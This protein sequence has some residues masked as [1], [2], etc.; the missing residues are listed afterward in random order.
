LFSHPLLSL[1]VARGSGD[2]VSQLGAVARQAGT[3]VSLH[4]TGGAWLVGGVGADAGRF[5]AAVPHSL[6]R[7]VCNTVNLCRIVN[8]RALDLVP[9]FLAALDAAGDRRG[10]PSRLHVVEGSEG[11][12]PPRWFARQVEVRRAEG[13]AVEP[14]ADIV[15]AGD[16]G[17]EWEWEENPEVTLLVVPAL[18]DAV[19]L[20]NRHSPRLVATLLS[21]DQSEQAVF[22][23]EI[24]AP[25]VGDGFTR[26]VDGQFAFDRPELGLSSW[27]HGR[28]FAR[29]GVLSGDAV[30]TLRTRAFQIDPDLSR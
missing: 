6:D 7:K 18:H 17:R 24:D 15:L 11:L 14:G 29:G 4:G 25:F 3:P 26:W 9:R 2:A 28:L 19:R 27:Q 16:L 5:D 1:A 8:D 30:F 13:R 20:F 12:V 21:Q 23:A 10:K 22:W